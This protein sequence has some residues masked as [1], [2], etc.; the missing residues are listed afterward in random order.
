MRR[1]LCVRVP[2]RTRGYCS[3]TD[4]SLAPPVSSIDHRSGALSQPG[5][6]SRVAEPMAPSRRASNTKLLAPPRTTTCAAVGADIADTEPR[7]SLVLH[8]DGAV[9]ID[10]DLRPPA[11]KR[12]AAEILD[13]R[14]AQLEPRRAGRQGATP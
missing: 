13:P 5:V 6:A 8:R 14:A 10:R 3:V 2:L 4:R 12:R 9:G 11:A 7:Q 1:N